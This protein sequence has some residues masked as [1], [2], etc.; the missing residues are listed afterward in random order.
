MQYGFNNPSY[1]YLM[2]GEVLIDTEEETDLGVTIHKS[3]NPILPY[4]T[5]CERVNQMLGMIRKSFPYNDR[6]TM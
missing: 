6:K 4:C 3:L 5:L 1:E 2:N